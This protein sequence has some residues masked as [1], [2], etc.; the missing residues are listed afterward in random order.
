METVFI[1]RPTGEAEK[2]LA[3]LEDMRRR[4]ADDI[5]TEKERRDA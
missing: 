4:M 2:V 3:L 1:G 5:S